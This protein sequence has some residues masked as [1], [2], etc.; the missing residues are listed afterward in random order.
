MYLIGVPEE[1]RKKWGRQYLK[2]IK[3][4]IPEIGEKH[5]KS[6]SGSSNNTN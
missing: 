3:G 2:E 1:E 4:G 6:K 5:Q